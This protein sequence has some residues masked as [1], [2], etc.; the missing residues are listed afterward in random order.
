MTRDR[1]ALVWASVVLAV[2]GFAAVGAGVIP[3]AGSGGES[4]SAPRRHRPA[5]VEWLKSR[6]ALADPATCLRRAGATQ[7]GPGVGGVWSAEVDSNPADDLT[8]IR[9][10]DA[11]TA[12]EVAANYG[13]ADSDTYAASAGRYLVTGPNAR[14]KAV[15][16]VTACLAGRR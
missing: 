13:Y 12:S 10:I 11:R 1:Q 16:R 8:V 15:E 3:G 2:L 7:A 5:V 14:A 9:K 4:Q 6:P